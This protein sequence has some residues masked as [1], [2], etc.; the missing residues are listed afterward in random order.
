[1]DVKDMDW[2]LKIVDSKARVELDLTS[3]LGVKTSLEFD[4]Q[5]L[6]KLFNSL[7]QTQLQIDRL[8]K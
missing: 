8:N 4:E 5:G 6:R 1:M 3:S 7:E 2:K